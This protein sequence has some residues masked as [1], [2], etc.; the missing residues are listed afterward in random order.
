LR[1][2]AAGKFD[3]RDAVKLEQLQEMDDQRRLQ[4]LL[5]IDAGI[6]DMPQ[7]RLAQDAYQYFRQGQMVCADDVPQAGLV[8]VYSENGCFTGIGEAL[9]DRQ[10]KPKRLLCTNS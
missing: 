7:V 10:I 3:V 5:P 2:T 1:R 6:D 8:R 9:E 4:Q